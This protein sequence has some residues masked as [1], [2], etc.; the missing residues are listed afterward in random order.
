MP[1]REAASPRSGEVVS[2]AKKN[3][4]AAAGRDK[5]KKSAARSRRSPTI[6]RRT[7][8]DL[9]AQIREQADTLAAVRACAF[10][11]SDSVGIERATIENQSTAL[12][13][14]AVSSKATALRRHEVD[15][16]AR[17]V[18]LDEV[19]KHLHVPPANV[20][21]A[22][23]NVETAA[24][25]I[26]DRFK[27]LRSGIVRAL[28]V[29]YSLDDQIVTAVTAREADR[30]Q[31]ASELEEHRKALRD[32][33]LDL[34]ACE[35]RAH[36]PPNTEGRHAIEIVKAVRELLGWSDLIALNPEDVRKVLQ[37]LDGRDHFSKL[38]EL[39]EVLQPRGIGFDPLIDRARH[40]VASVDELRDRANQH[41]NAAAMLERERDDARRERDA[42]KSE[43]EEA[44]RAH[45]ETV[46]DYEEATRDMREGLRA[47]ARFISTLRRVEC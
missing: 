32:L 46:A 5:P 14:S 29:D 19:V 12:I 33:R 16:T 41:K 45:R 36:A 37:P 6:S 21:G 25:N 20:L 26:L 42:V 34:K 17:A 7:I 47:A 22:I 23:R 44:T 39:H 11:A 24:A 43:T 15:Q 13:L 27:S 18:L 4:Y 38:K 30:E 8:L 1:G 9:E 31:L 40:V 35:D 2:A 3:R 28:G 10:R